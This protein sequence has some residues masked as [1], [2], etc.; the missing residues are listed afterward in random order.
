MCLHYE[1]T[2]SNFIQLVLS[3]L[4]KRNYSASPCTYT[5][6]WQVPNLLIGGLS[7]SDGV[8]KSYLICLKYFERQTVLLLRDLLIYP[9]KLS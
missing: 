7:C 1:K 3:G 4:E 6:N 2:N 8:N 5:K 9:Y